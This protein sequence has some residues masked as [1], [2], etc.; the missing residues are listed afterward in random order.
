MQFLAPWAR[1]LE[2]LGHTVMLIPP[3]YV[4]PIVR[5]Q[6]TD[7]AD[8]MA[9]CEAMGR[10]GMRCVPVRS[11]ENQAAKMVHAVRETLSGVSGAIAPPCGPEAQRRVSA[12]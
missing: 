1:Q 8:A 6:K 11:I 4:K 3:A 2:A 9:I 5:R 7:A 12:P 10:P